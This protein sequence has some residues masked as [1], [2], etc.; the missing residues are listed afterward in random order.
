M[1]WSYLMLN[2]NFISIDDSNRFMDPIFFGDYP[3]S[4]RHYLGD[5]LPKFTLEQSALI[6]GS[7]DWIGFN[8]YSSLYASNTNISEQNDNGVGLTCMW[9]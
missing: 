6:K 7:Y 9:S 2:H 5:R 1:L 8:H 3:A 4:M